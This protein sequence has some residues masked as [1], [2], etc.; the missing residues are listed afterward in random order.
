ARAPTRPGTADPF[1]AGLTRSNFLGRQ[2]HLRHGR[3]HGR[4]PWLSAN[5][6]EQRPVR[7]IR[8]R[9]PHA[10]W[11]GV[12]CR[13]RLTIG[14]R[15]RVRLVGSKIVP[16]VLEVDPFTALDERFWRRPIEP[17]MP[18]RRIVID[19]YPAFN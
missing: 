19:G 14:L 4:R 2:P 9:R 15:N 7:E 10:S 11:P 8:P 6:K 16:E 18:G 13:V 3:G 12:G 5:N 17:K 1:R